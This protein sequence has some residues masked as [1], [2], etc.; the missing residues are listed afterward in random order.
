MEPPPPPRVRRNTRGMTALY[1]E[2]PPQPHYQPPPPH[3]PA[4]EGELYPGES[5]WG[6]QFFEPP[7]YVSPGPPGG[8]PGLR[9]DSYNTSRILAGLNNSGRSEMEP[10][11]ALNISSISPISRNG[12]VFEGGRRKRS[13]KAKRSKKRSKKTRRR[14]R[15]RGGAMYPND[16]NTVIVDREDDSPD[17]V[18]RVRSYNSALD[19][20]IAS[21]NSSV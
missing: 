15:Q 19:N 20:P 3:P 16:D 2:Q 8:S 9:Y 7:P 1:N 4:P 18:M 13:K 10:T 11:G 12:S 14:R 6:P 5:H 21:Q 17:S